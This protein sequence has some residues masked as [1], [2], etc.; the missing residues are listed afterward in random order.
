M[1]VNLFI[2]VIYYRG[3]VNSNA[4]VLLVP[5]IKMWIRATCGT[6]LSNS[7]IVWLWCT[8]GAAS[9]ARLSV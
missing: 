4:L 6:S 9:E 1:D 7:G 5:G 2:F 3:G 8:S